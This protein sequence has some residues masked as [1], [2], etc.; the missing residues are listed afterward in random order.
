ML[1]SAVFSSKSGITARKPSPSGTG[2]RQ[3]ITWSSSMA[4][5]TNPPSSAGVELSGWPSATAARSTSSSRVQGRPSSSLAPSSAPAMHAEEL[6]SPLAVGMPFHWRM[7]S[8]R[9]GLPHRA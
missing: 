3:A 2:Q 4:A 1:T 8:P 9:K 6:P 7:C 5:A